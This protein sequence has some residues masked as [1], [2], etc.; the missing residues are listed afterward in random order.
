[1][2]S[3]DLPDRKKKFSGPTPQSL[4]WQ[5]ENTLFPG[6]QAMN[7][8]QL[9]WWSGA[10]GIQNNSSLLV[11]RRTTR[12]ILDVG[13]RL[14][15]LSGFVL[16]LV[17]FWLIL[18]RRPSQNRRMGRKKFNLCNKCGFRHTAP[19]GKA[20]AAGDGAHPLEKHDSGDKSVPGGQGLNQE[21]LDYAPKI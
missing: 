4:C 12:I 9:S 11:I 19:T 2:K 5:G 21:G 15:F 8:M 3:C 6:C 10:T 20:C 1:M 18:Y 7:Q 13:R 16:K 17:T 14:R